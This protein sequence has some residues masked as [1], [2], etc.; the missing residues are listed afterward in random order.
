MQ[1]PRRGFTLIELL[2]V[3][4]V[5][6]LLIGILLP[7]LGAAR[8]QAIAVGCAS[9]LKQLGLGIG[10]YY[11]DFPNTLPQLRTNDAGEIVRPGDADQGEN[12]GS[13]FG[14]KKGIIPFIGIDQIGA[15]RRPLNQYVYDGELPPDD[16]TEADE[17][18]L[19]IFRSPADAGTADPFT[20][21]L[22]LPTD[23][24]YELLGSSY[25]LNDHALDDT[26]F[27]ELYPT[28]IPREGGRIPRIRH[29]S[30]VWVLGSHPIYNYDDGTD[31][32]QRWYRSSTVEASL[33]FF[34][35]HAKAAVE[36]AEGVT[37][38]T[39]DYTFLPSPDWLD[40]FGTPPL[41]P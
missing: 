33:L 23:S 7:A 6:A 15:E 17:F 24:M 28:L 35:G 27:A 32:G 38:E 4:A 9:N 26:A 2:V 21:S 10:L 14:G 1:A 19:E 12:I 29:S 20:V 36:V 18:E 16:S 5:I 22:G 34:D 8:R 30:K 11:N 13:L 3:V 31:R 39:P 25:T 37:Q 40:Q 41:G